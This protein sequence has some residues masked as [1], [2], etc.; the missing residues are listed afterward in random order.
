MSLLER[1]LD[2]N[3]IT[4]TLD[5]V[6]NW[7]RKSS[8]WPMSFGLACC[9]IEMMATVSSRYDIDRFGAGVFRASPRQ[10]DLMIVAGTVTRKMA[11]VI[12]RIYDQMPEPRYVI[13]MG[14]CATSGNHYNSYSVV[15]GVDQ[16]VPVDVY[17]PGCPPRPEA[18]LDG[19][20]KLQEKIQREKVFVK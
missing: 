9:A 5:A 16:I 17:V 6:T 13:S 14:S 11:E 8:L 4:T 18:L 15:Q 12:R 2:A 7:A 3:V 1:Q 20:L 19:L 10:A